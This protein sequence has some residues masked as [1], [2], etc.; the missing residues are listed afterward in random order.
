MDRTCQYCDQQ[1]VAQPDGLRTIYSCSNDACAN[2]APF[3]VSTTEEAVEHGFWT[4]PQEEQI[5]RLERIR[6]LTRAGVLP[7][8]RG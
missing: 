8:V 5:Q 6:K 3:A 2:W 1:L 4:R 7:V